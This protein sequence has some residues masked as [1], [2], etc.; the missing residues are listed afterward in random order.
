MVRKLFLQMSLPQILT[1]I[2]TTLCLLIDSIVIG[3]LLGVEQ[4]SAYGFASPLITIITSFGL[5]ISTGVQEV[6]GK[7]IGAGDRDGS[8]RCF[9]TSL[10]LAITFGFG[11]LIFV[12]VL[13]NPLCTFLGAGSP[14]ADNAVFTMTG[15]YL[16]GFTLGAPAYFLTQLMSPYLQIGG[17]RRRIT[18]SVTALTVAD[19][20]ADLLSVFVFHGGMFGI[21]LASSL[22]YVV[23]VLVD[24]GFFLKKDCMFRFNMKDSSRETFLEIFKG[25]SPI[26]ICQICFTIRVYIF[27]HILMATAGTVAVAVYASIS[28]LG[29]L[30]FCVGLGTGS[31][32]LTLSSIFYG[33]EDRPSLCELV[34][35]M[36][37][38]SLV[39]I[40]SVV[41]LAELFAPWLA[42][43]S[44]GTAPEVVAISVPALQI[45]ELSLIPCVMI[46]TYKYFYQGS[47]RLMLT[48]IISILDALV[49]TGIFAWLGGLF[50]GL[51]GI[52]VG[53]GVG[54]LAVCVF[55]V[56]VAWRHH[57]GPP[58][59]AEAMSMLDDDFGAAPE[60]CFDAPI[61]D[62]EDALV[63]S[64]RAQD[65]CIRRL[66]DHK[67][68]YY[69]GLCIEEMTVNIIEHGFTKDNKPHNI[70]VRLVINGDDRLIRIRDNCREFDPIAY[71]ELHQ[72]DDP[73]SSLG[74]RMV[75]AMVKDAKYINTL[76]LN[77][78]LLRL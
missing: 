16:K 20:V 70:D 32:T 77:N 33:E 59:S 18:I 35:V 72:N 8:N 19:V 29:N 67:T 51:T 63:V 54:E 75:M 65:F 25:G 46:N 14:S 64:E 26:V 55:I 13:C 62:I 24:I 66:I 5:M 60:D 10:I 45:Y 23:A 40:L 58:F 21:G 3:R 49:L 52:W 9:S 69:I 50:F 41:V 71:L 15:D 44:L 47:G 31:V 7:T 28:I 57:G 74:I 37:A 22:S 76:G 78:L 36:T 68:A 30:F 56:L 2:S 39:M 42:R 34:R 53:I 27:N 6:C 17:N 43:L 48:H 4:M 11:S 38:C 61:A 12:F 73:I 1:A